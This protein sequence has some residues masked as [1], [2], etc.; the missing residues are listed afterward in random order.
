MKKAQLFSE[1]GLSYGAC[2]MVHEVTAGFSLGRV[3]PPA[4]L[5]NLHPVQV[6][7]AHYKVAA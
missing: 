4:L 3:T 5:R 2:G 7:P 6:V 1:Q